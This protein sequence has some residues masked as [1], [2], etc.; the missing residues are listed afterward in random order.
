MIGTIPVPLSVW[1]SKLT[2]NLRTSSRNL[3]WHRLALL[4]VQCALPSIRGCSWSGGHR[5]SSRFATFVKCTRTSPLWSCSHQAGLRRVAAVFTR[6]YAWFVTRPRSEML[7]P[8][9]EDFCSLHYGALIALGARTERGRFT[10]RSSIKRLPGLI[11]VEFLH[12]HSRD[13]CKLLGEPV[14][15]KWSL[16]R[17]LQGAGLSTGCQLVGHLCRK[18]VFDSRGLVALTPSVIF[19]RI[20]FAKSLFLLW[21]SRVTILFQNRSLLRWLPSGLYHLRCAD[22]H[23]TCGQTNLG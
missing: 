14:E 12:F 18:V 5:C 7:W 15:S 20:D 13:C 16:I 1:A 3:S 2:W 22:E 17:T 10:S 8:S 4:S 9:R 21:P 23:W 19:S 11:C 6:S